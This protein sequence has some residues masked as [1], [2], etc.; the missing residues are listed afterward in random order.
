VELQG[1]VNGS[2]RQRE[3]GHGP[4]PLFAAADR[5][6][7][8]AQGAPCLDDLIQAYPRCRSRGSR[9]DFTR[10]LKQY[11]EPDHEIV[12]QYFAKH[13][14]A[15]ALHM[16]R[17]TRFRRRRNFEIRMRYPGEIV[18]AVQP[19]FEAALW[20][21]RAMEQQTALL[22]SGRPRRVLLEMLFSVIVYLLG[23]LDSVECLAAVGRGARKTKEC[24]RVHRIEKALEIAQS[25]LTRLQ[26]FAEQAAIRAAL[27]HYVIGLFIGGMAVFASAWTASQVRMFEHAP[28]LD[29]VRAIAAGGLGAI[30]S[31]MIRISRGQRLDVDTTQEPFMTCLAG[32]SRLVI[33]GALGVALYV[34]LKAEFVPLEIPVESDA[35]APYFFTAIA[36]LAGFSERWAQDTIVRSTPLSTSAGGPPTPPTGTP[37]ASAPTEAAA[38]AVTG[39]GLMTTDL[40][41]SAPTAPDGTDSSRQPP[42]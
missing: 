11:R 20:R 3:N 31:V 15:G 2:P 40:P 38:S 10:L 8:C 42:D 25:E 30:I 34:L 33:G 37:R 41:A 19:E 36:F 21:A 7:S 35:A 23:V 16:C 18:A 14:H 12:D 32:S 24:S 17:R 26:E 5:E 1:V 4:R 39:V 29:L 9:E 28:T 6:L 22:V 27:K 13:I